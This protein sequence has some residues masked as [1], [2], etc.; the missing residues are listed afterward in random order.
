V[1]DPDAGVVNHVTLSLV[2]VWAIG[3]DIKVRL[4][5]SVRRKLDL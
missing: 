3:V 1:C 4:A 2:L 5:L